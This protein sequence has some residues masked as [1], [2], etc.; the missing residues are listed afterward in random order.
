MAARLVQQNPLVLGTFAEA[1]KPVGSFLV[2][3]LAKELAELSKAEAWGE[4]KVA[5]VK[6]QANV[7]VALVVLGRGEK[8][9]PLLKHNPDPTLRSFLIDRL[10][11]GG[12]E[13]KVL[14]DQFDREQDISIKRAILLSLGEFSLDRLSQAERQNLLPRLLQLYRDDPDPGIH[15]AAEW[16]LR[17]WQAEGTLKEIDSELATGKVEGMRQ[18]YVNRQGQTMMIAPK[19]GVFWM[20]RRKYQITRSYAIA[21]KEVTVNDFLAF[22]KAHTFDKQTADTRSCPVNCVSWYVAAAYCNWLSQ[23]EGIPKE[24]WCYEP[25]DKG[26][27][28]EGMKLASNSLI[29]TGY[30]MPSELEWYYASQAGADTGLFFGNMTDLLGKYAWY[31]RTSSAKSHPVGALKPNDL[32]LFDTHGNVW[33]W[34]HGTG[35]TDKGEEVMDDTDDDTVVTEKEGR[36]LCGG[37]FYNPERQVQSS[38]SGPFAPSLISNTTGFRLARTFR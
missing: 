15:S 38:N 37:A 36:V 28:A 34:C 18:W 8:V 24:Q 35:K 11:P 32:G 16:L 4:A 31:N 2:P 17:Q 20:K 10:A 26:Q 29:R 13:A 22:R 7:S 30:R 21:S 6:R 19:P 1:L 27:Y 14:M 33:E 9:W 23:E 3:P 25:N 12:V 5:L